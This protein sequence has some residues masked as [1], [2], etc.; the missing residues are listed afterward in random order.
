MTFSGTDVLRYEV[1]GHK[2]Y[3][4]L[5]R[6]QAMN[7]LSEP[8]RD[9]LVQAL[10]AI[11]ADETVRV[12]ILGGEGGRA[13]SAGMDLKEMAQTDA[14]SGPTTEGAISRSGAFSA[15]RDCRKP[16]IAAIDG[17]CVAAGL[18]LALLCDIRVAT[19]QSQFGLPEPRRSLL[20]GPGL[21]Y[22]SRTV[23]LGEA[24][25]MQLTGSP[26]SAERAYQIG[27]IQRVADTRD[28]MMGQAD[29]I[30]DEIL[31]CAPLAV[32]AIKRVVRIAR[33]VPPEYSEHFAAPIEEA[34][35]GSEDRLEGP[36][37]FA[38]KRDPQWKGH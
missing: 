34:V 33:N 38:E 26:I 2:A 30:A 16:V 19:A 6:P 20:A 13:F 17:H 27:L 18:E 28:E 37:A 31:L 9:S 5:N 21:H 25:L 14:A 7:A 1:A 4:V 29:A 22:L 32:Q 15:L 8:L 12:V 35:Y 10:E 11:A 24:L 3:V 23:P 36:K